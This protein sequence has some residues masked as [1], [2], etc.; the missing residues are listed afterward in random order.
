MMVVVVEDE[1]EWN[2][3]LISTSEC[4]HRCMK[5]LCFCEAIKTRFLDQGDGMSGLVGDR[6][7][8]GKLG[9]ADGENPDLHASPPS[10]R[11][12]WGEGCGF[13]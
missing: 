4:D 9:F 12:S 1:R 8:P 5:Y 13:L 2:Q 3:Q 7:V 11:G 6:G 10:L